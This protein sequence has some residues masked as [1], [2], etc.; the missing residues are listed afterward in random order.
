[1]HLTSAISSFALGIYLILLSKDYQD[2]LQNNEAKSALLEVSFVV[3][4]ISV[5][6]STV[7]VWNATE[8]A[9]LL[10][11]GRQP[12]DLT[13]IDHFVKQEMRQVLEIN[14]PK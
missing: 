6:F 2:D 8:L 13:I 4:I 9:I 11:C 3:G 5:I 1:M 12:Q 10:F 14:N 7:F